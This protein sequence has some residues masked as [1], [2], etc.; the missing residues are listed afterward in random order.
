[1]CMICN[2]CHLHHLLLLLL[3]LCCACC[4]PNNKT[5]AIYGTHIAVIYAPLP[6]QVYAGALLH[7]CVAASAVAASGSRLLTL[8]QHVHMLQALM[9]L[10]A[11]FSLHSICLLCGVDEVYARSL[12]A[13]RPLLI[14]IGVG[15]VRYLQI[16]VSLG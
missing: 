16:H 4:E 13:G 15:Q 14:V 2:C 9:H 3:T 7:L 8:P 6:C 12:W 10:A 1:M 11:C 5:T